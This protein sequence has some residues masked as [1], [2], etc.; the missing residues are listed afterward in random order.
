MI[1]DSIITNGI[2]GKNNTDKGVI[3]KIAILGS[4][5]MLGNAVGRY[6]LEKYGEND[7]FLSYKNEDVSYGKKRFYFDALNFLEGNRHILP[8]C[9]YII[10]CIGV[11]KPFMNA[12]QKNAIKLNSLFPLILADYCENKKPNLIHITTDCVFSGKD[13]KYTETSAHDALD[14]YGKSKSLGEYCQKNCMV[15]RTSIIGEE[16]HKKASLLEWVKSQKDKDVNGFTNHYWN[17]VTTKQY[18]KICSQIID[19]NLYSAGLFHAFSNIVSKYELVSLI[20]EKFNLNININPVEAD[21]F[22]DRT[23]ST[24]KQLNSNLE[25][26]S[27]K[28]QIFEL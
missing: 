4:T 11:I 27:L 5:G 7:V 23:L 15:L 21:V 12:N 13:G 1:L 20:N 6:F 22:C 19:A 28:E 16:I 25:I 9:D 24:E 26:P 10:N 3:M 2:F 14:D 18:A 8:E 17:G